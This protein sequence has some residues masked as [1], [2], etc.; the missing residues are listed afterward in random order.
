MAE[1][2]RRSRGDDGRGAPVRGTRSLTAIL[3][4][5]R[6]VWLN[7]KSPLATAGA[8]HRIAQQAESSARWRRA[9]NEQQ[10]EAIARPTTSST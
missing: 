7:A 5:G 3:P 4:S 10:R 9:A 2:T 8:V 1:D 6:V